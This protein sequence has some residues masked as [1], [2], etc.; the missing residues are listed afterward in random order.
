MPVSADVLKLR[1]AYIWANICIV[2]TSTV[3]IALSTRGRSLQLPNL[4]REFLETLRRLLNLSNH[5][6]KDSTFWR[7]RFHLGDISCYINQYISCIAL[8]LGE[9]GPGQLGTVKLGSGQLNHGQLGPGQL[10]PNFHFFLWAEFAQFALNPCIVII[11][12]VTALV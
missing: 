8:V 10:G 1:S 6:M 12:D 9:L 4:A 5:E 3:L 11:G 2:Y 7:R